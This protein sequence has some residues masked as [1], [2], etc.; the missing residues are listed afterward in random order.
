MRRSRPDLTITS[1]WS[2]ACRLAHSIRATKQKIWRFCLRSVAGAAAV[3]RAI[4]IAKFQNLK[5]L[6][7]DHPKR[8]VRN[9]AEERF[10]STARKETRPS[11]GL[12]SAHY[13]SRTSR[14]LA[15]STTDRKRRNVGRLGHDDERRCSRRE[16]NDLLIDRAARIVSARFVRSRR[17][18]GISA[19]SREE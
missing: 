2:P 7:C 4:E 16:T 14:G 11:L 18:R 1:H 15:G 10:L 17:A 6:G 8:R 19:R 13:M 9:C 3:K 12:A 5:A